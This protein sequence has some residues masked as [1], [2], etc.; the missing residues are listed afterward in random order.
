LPRYGHDHFVSTT[1]I[2]R[3]LPQ[4]T[5]WLPG[6]AALLAVAAVFHILEYHYL[7]NAYATHMPHYDSMGSYM[8]MYEVRNA[9]HAE[10]F[11]PA[12]K[13]ASGHFLSWA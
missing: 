4:K 5:A 9:L 13:L 8:Y 10:G 3:Y 1:F 2:C 7:K 12:L 6:F 11:F